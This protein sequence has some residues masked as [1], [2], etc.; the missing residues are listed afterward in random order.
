MSTAIWTIGAMQID[1]QIISNFASCLDKGYEICPNICPCLNLPKMLHTESDRQIKNSSNQLTNIL[2]GKLV[3]G[4]SGLTMPSFYGNTGG[5]QEE[6][7]EWR[8]IIQSFSSFQ[9]HFSGK[10]KKETLPEAQ[11][12]QDIDSIRFFLTGTHLHSCYAPLRSPYEKLAK[13]AG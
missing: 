11:W 4:C 6:S 12:F 1:W 2:T 8:S 3:L 5:A 7:G 9:L 13:M 10:S